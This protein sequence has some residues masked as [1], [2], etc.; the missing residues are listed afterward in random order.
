MYIRFCPQGK[1]PSGKN[2]DDILNEVRK[3]A[4]GKINLLI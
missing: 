3:A 1:L 2:T 4:F